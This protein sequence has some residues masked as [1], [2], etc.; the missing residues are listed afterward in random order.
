[1]VSRRENICQYFLPKMKL[2]RYQFNS[3]PFVTIVDDADCPASPYA[4]AYLS[5][6]TGQAFNTQLRKANELL[7]V[8]NHFQKKRI[9]MV[10]RVKSGELIS[11]KEYLQFH[12]AAASQKRGELDP[13][14][15]LPDVSD[16]QLR[17]AISANARQ[18][19][20]VSNETQQ[21]RLRRLR[22]YLE[23]LFEHCHDPFSVNQTINDRHEKLKWAIKLDEDSLSRNKSQQVADASESV[24]PDQV[25]VRL[26]E[27]ILPSSPNNPFKGS[28]IRNYL[29]VS[30]LY[31]SGI[32]RGALAKLKISDCH[33]HGSYD[34][35]KIYRSG[36]DATDPRLD[37]PNQK[38][39]AHLATISPILMSQ[40]KY[41]I[42]HVRNVVPRSNEND[43]IFLSEKGSRGTLGHPLSLRSINGVFHVLSDALGFYIHPHL[44]RHKWN[45]IFDK[46]GTEQGID[47]RLLEDA[48]K[49]AM[50]WVANSL[51]SETYND[52][53]LAQKAREIS[54][55]H[56]KRVDEQR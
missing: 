31:Q 18:L 28:K 27:M 48:R 23:W 49:Y 9:D 19:V 42:D 46:E 16:K 33:F 26:L 12:T 10:Q 51:M 55:A 4:S 13:V 54:A 38:T 7:F 14:A 35:I 15:S 56:Q 47:H 5:T 1:M 37:K 21:G 29:I 20:S 44:L 6:L 39:K 34:Q 8:L 22:Q 32:R 17:N 52:K 25:F 2:K 36:F 30:I 11:L 41:Y 50:G 24:I 3:I 45:E 43:F 53:R 40:I